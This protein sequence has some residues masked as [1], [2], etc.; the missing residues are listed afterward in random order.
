MDVF[1]VENFES[2]SKLAVRYDRAKAQ[3]DLH[4]ASKSSASVIELMRVSLSKA[5]S[6]IAQYVSEIMPSEGGE[7]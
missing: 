7:M 5:E 1:T 3:F 6:N 2:L 4:V